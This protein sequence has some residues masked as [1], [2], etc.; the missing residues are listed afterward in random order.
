MELSRVAE[1][2]VE[3]AVQIMQRFGEA[4]RLTACRAV[5]NGFENLLEALSHGFS[6]PR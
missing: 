2:N 5:R 6:L 3:K 4:C 1:D